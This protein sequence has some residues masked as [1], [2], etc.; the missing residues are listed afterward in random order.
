MEKLNAAQNKGSSRSFRFFLSLTLFT[1]VVLS[2]L[3]LVH[4]YSWAGFVGG[5][6]GVRDRSCSLAWGN[7]LS[8]RSGANGRVCYGSTTNGVGQWGKNLCW[9]GNSQGVIERPASLG[10]LYEQGIPNH[11]SDPQIQFNYLFA[12]RPI[13]SRAS[14]SRHYVPEAPGARKWEGL[15]P[16]CRSPLF[17]FIFTM[18]LSSLTFDKPRIM[19]FVTSLVFMMHGVDAQVAVGSFFDNTCALMWGKMLCWGGNSLGESGLFS[20]ANIADG[21]AGHVNI[22]TAAF[23]TFSPTG[24]TVVQITGYQQTC[25]LFQS[26]KVRCWG[27][28]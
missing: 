23:L 7:M 21:V 1:A 13:L 22:S 6:K 26:G 3:P 27:T 4:S 12:P 25:A 8:W 15:F 20:T 10:L 2:C 24:D 14:H 28:L 16:E 5:G 18:L 19:I 9:G 11:N 17:G